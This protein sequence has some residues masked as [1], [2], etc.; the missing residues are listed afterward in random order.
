MNSPLL[1]PN[2]FTGISLFSGI[3]GVD[4]GM[5]QAGIKPVLAVEY[6][7]L[8]PRLSKYLADTHDLNFKKYGSTVLRE[9]VQSV[10][11]SGTL[12]V[13]FC[14]FLH[15]SPVCDNLSKANRVTSGETVVD[16]ELAASVIKCLKTLNPSVFTLEQVPDYLFTRSWKL[17]HKHLKKEGYDTV[18]GVLNMCDYGVPQKQRLRLIVAAS[19]YFKPILPKTNSRSCPTWWET[20]KDI[21]PNMLDD[22]LSDYQQRAIENYHD[23]N[24]NVLITPVPVFKEC[25]IFSE[26]ELAPTI[27]RSMCRR[28]RVLTLKTSDGVVKNL[29][30]KALARLQGFPDWFEIPSKSVQGIGYA[31]PPLFAY[32]LF[33]TLKLQLSAATFNN[34]YIRVIR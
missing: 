14:D 33:K 12:P 2:C 15:A 30:I 27:T 22:S 20:I 25:R 32:Q 21:V 3:G 26:R 13:N 17:I 34:E 23:F 28:T 6:N 18:Y 5:V 7:P 31:V 24:S 11:V 4:C 9:T 10:A 19:R 16:V 29:S 1:H 8:N